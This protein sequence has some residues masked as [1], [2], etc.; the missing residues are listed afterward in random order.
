MKQ[1]VTIPGTLQ[2]ICR[3]SATPIKIQVGVC[4]FVCVKQLTLTEHHAPMIGKTALQNSNKGSGL[5]F[6]TH[7]ATVIK[8]NALAQG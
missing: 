8:V 2:L 5:A 1:L 4:V 6:L 7:K 3:F